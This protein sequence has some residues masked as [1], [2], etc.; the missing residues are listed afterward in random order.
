MERGLPISSCVV[1][2]ARNM[3]LRQGGSVCGRDRVEWWE[4]GW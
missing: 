3:E 4:G 2:I 1:A